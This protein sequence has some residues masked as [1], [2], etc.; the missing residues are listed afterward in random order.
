[1]FQFNPLTHT[2]TLDGYIIPS[3]TQVLK[4]EGFIDTQ[5]CTDW[6]R[7]KGQQVHLATHLDDMNDLVEE[8]VDPIIAPYLEAWRE[9]RSVT[10]FMVEGS[11]T[12]LVSATFRYFGIPDRWGYISTTRVVIDLK[13]GP[14]S[15]WV[16]L[17]TAAQGLLIDPSAHFKRF[18]LTLKNGKPKITEFTDRSDRGVFLGAL[19]SYNWKRNH[20]KGYCNESN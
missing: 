17:Q 2:G 15:P 6:D 8:S 3:I 7:D 9:F 16:A 5:W 10:G 18:G 1:M 20:L 12:P 14:C 4:A 11:E 19:A 13:S